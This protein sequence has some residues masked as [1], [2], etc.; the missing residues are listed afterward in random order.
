M[1]DGS[2][3]RHNGEDS[4]VVPVRPVVSGKGLPT[5]PRTMVLVLVVG[6]ITFVAGLQL[7]GGRAAPVVTPVPSTLVLVSPTPEPDP[8]PAEPIVQ[9][10][11]TSDFSR[12]FRPQDTIASV[13]G[14]SSCVT[15]DESTD[16]A[17][18]QVP[19]YLHMWSLYCTIK[20]AD[21]GAFIQ[22]VADALLS[23]IPLTSGSSQSDEQGSMVAK[24][25]YVETRFEGTVML[26]SGPAGSG[27]GI[28]ITLN[29]V[30]Y[31]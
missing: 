18:V 8:T 12:S 7:G 5:V 4:G 13:T 20:K 31:P 15:R 17:D 14:G 3:W 22:A 21:R 9:G 26:T 16:G 10:A 30:T 24:F 23:K 11:D 1:H 27:Y 25:V 6:L 19:A 2:E 28:V 29:E